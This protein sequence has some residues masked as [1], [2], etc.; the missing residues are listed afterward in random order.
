M[1]AVVLLSVLG[2][3]LAQER[4]FSWSDPGQPI[5]PDPTDNACVTDVASCGCCLMQKQMWKMES[6]FNMSLNE[7]QRGLDRAHAVLN[8]IRVSRS[9]FSVA[10]TD[11]RLCVGPNREDSVLKYGKVFINLGEGYNSS[12]GVFTAPRSGVYSLALT[13]YSDSGSAGSVLAACARLRLNGRTI[14]SPTEKNTQDQE[15]SASALLAVQMLAGDHLDVS[16][17]AGCF[18][19]DDNNHYN[20]F[21]GFLLYSTD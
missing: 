4:L 21:T 6:F 15:D 3:A 18:L 17:P 11:S 2:C 9:A 1:K 13:L 16:L 14:A 7:L 20:T 8:N 12:S 19:C 10:L 5:Q